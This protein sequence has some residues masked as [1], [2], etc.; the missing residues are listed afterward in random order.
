MSLKKLS[1]LL[2]LGF[3][4][5]LAACAPVTP[6]IPQTGIET[7]TPFL[8]ETPLTLATE[9]SGVAQETVVPNPPILTEEQIGSIVKT[10]VSGQLQVP[11]DQI[12]V[13]SAARQEWPDACLG[14]PKVNEICAQ[15]IT[16]GWLVVLSDNGKE[17]NV[18]TDLTAQNIRVVPDTME[19]PIVGMTAT[20][21]AGTPLAVTPT[22][23]SGAQTGNI[24]LYLVKLEDNGQSG[25]LIGCGDSLVTVD[26]S[27]QPS[28]DL[29]NQIRQAYEAIL[30]ANPA[31]Y[32]GQNLYNALLNAGLQV[33]SVTVQNENAVIRLFGDFALGGVCDVP[34]VE[35]QLKYVGLQ[36]DG[37][38]DV[39]IYLNNVPLADAI[40]AKGDGND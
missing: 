32:P 24:Q 30:S 12:K 34:R 10:W 19:T 25:M 7:T 33:G 5:L 17:Y 38:K 6:S 8:T 20:P 14:L 1:A 27:V 40:S 23:Q 15:V 29:A 11:V 26:S 4:M 21:L 28:G 18:R 36:F 39:E 3:L 35:Q 9:T 37:V 2:M 13:V 22:S 16:P 31:D